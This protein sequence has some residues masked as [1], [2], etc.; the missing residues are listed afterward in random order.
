MP[1][2]L[3]LKRLNFLG[4]NKLF[5]DLHE[6]NQKPISITEKRLLFLHTMYK[7]EQTSTEEQATV[8]SKIKAQITIRPTLLLRDKNIPLFVPIEPVNAKYDFSSIDAGDFSLSQVA[9]KLMGL[10][11]QVTTRIFN[12]N[13]LT[14]KNPNRDSK[15]PPYLGS[16]ADQQIFSKVF[17]SRGEL[18]KPLGP[19]VS[20]NNVTIKVRP[21]FIKPAFRLKFE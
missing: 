21:I 18:N 1:I 19:T 15:L 11:T 3:S 7:Y 17:F 14:V 2:H 9:L 5:L 13:S 10:P 20:F 16:R 4:I 8:P 6:H 12:I